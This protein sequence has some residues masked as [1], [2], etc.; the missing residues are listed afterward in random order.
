MKSA[1]NNRTRR[2]APPFVALLE[3]I[4]GAYL[5]ATLLHSA[6]ADVLLRTRYKLQHFTGTLVM[7]VSLVW[8]GV[9]LIRQHRNIDD[10]VIVG[11]ES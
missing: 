9:I 2:G 5:R 11:P 3:F 6:G 10:S 4:V 1:I 7:L 8:A